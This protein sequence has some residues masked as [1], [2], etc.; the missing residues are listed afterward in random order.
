L[1]ATSRRATF[2]GMYVVSEA[3]A[4]AIREVYERDGELSADIELRRVSRASRTTSR[5]GNK[6]GPS[7]AGRRCW[8]AEAMET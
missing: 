5:P 1:P 3:D 2:I 6:R 4:A 8:P 7:L